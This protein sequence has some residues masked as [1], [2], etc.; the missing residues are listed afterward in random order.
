[1]KFNVC[2]KEID[3]RDDDNCGKES[4]T[5][6]EEGDSANGSRGDSAN[7]GGR[8]GY[9]GRS[10]FEVDDLYLIGICI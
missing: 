10:C 8:D 3:S 7:G 5:M 6:I 2:D 4:V 1:M 9:N